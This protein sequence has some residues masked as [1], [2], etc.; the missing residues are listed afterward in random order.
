MQAQSTSKGRGSRSKK[1]TAR[2]S[3]NE[4][5]EEL[6]AERLRLSSQ[7]HCV[8]YIIASDKAL[9]TLALK[10]PCT[11]AGIKDCEGAINI[12]FCV[13]NDNFDDF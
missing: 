2:A 1:I 5:L 3:Q 8:P 13:F 12:F 4:L 6:K 11:L 9:M 7:L 10:R